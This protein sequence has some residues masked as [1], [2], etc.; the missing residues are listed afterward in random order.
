MLV[1]FANSRAYIPP[2]DACRLVPYTLGFYLSATSCS[3][4]VGLPVTIHRGGLSNASPPFHVTVDGSFISQLECHL[5]R[6]RSTLTPCPSVFHQEPRSVYLILFD[7]LRSLR[8]EQ[9][10]LS[11]PVYCCL[12]TYGL[13]DTYKLSL[14]PIEIALKIG[15]L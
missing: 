15:R 13:E 3:D 11:S 9:Y 7:Q 1:M 6:G 12:A 10:T 8:E 4:V 2:Q 14:L 5:V